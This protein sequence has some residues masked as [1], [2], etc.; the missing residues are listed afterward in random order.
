[1]IGIEKIGYYIPSGRISN[2][3]RLKE[4]DM[5]ED[6]VVNK[7]G[8]KEISQKND[9]ETVV[10]MC[11]KACV[12]LEKQL[13]YT[14]KEI[15]VLV[16]VTQNP[17]TNIPHT[18]AMLHEKLGLP[19]SCAT[20]DISLGCSGYVSALSIL[21]GFMY[22]NG[23]KKGI[24]VTCDP[25]SKVVD[26]SDKNTALLFGDAATATLLSENYTFELGKFT[27]GTVSEKNDALYVRNGKLEM[28]GRSIFNFASTEIP[29]DIDDLL[30]RNKC[31]SEEV[32][33][34]LFHPGSKYVINSIV[35]R[36]KID[37][38]KVS[39]DNSEYGN[40]ISSSIPLLLKNEIS[41]DKDT[42]LLS[43]FGVG[44]TWGSVIIRRRYEY[45]S[46]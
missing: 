28:K 8:I 36:A 41:S 37:I 34:Y 26:K 46:K 19:K 13:G 21:Q 45:N 31:S 23:M 6:F 11:E 14:D 22:I 9:E 5:T 17:D 44:L 10:E 35:D 30:E 2:L 38:N 32:D 1:M 3:G 29:Q 42:I 15:D 39:Y 4:F 24:L 40:A 43:G 20:F 33:L 16:V 12:N 18:S 27:F 25:Y 7:L